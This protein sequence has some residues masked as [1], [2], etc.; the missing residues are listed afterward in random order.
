MKSGKIISG[1]LGIA[2]SAGA[3]GTAFTTNIQTS[4]ASATNAE[5]SYIDIGQG[6][7][8]LLQVNGYTVLID[9]GEKG[10]EDK[11]L[12]YLES[13]DIDTINYVIASHPHSDHIGGLTNI[14]YSII[15]GK[16]DLKIE[17]IISCDMDDSVQPTT[18]VYKYFLEDSEEI[19]ANFEILETRKNIKLGD[20]TLTLIPSPI[21]DDS[22]INNE[23]IVTLL[24]NGNNIFL[25]TGDAETEEESL[26][27]KSNVFA[28][29]TVDVYKAGHHG[30]S[31]ASSKLLLAEIKPKYTVISC[32][33]GNSY[34]HPHKETLS[35]LATYN[36]E[37]LRTDLQGTIVFKS[38]GTN[39]SFETEKSYTSENTTNPTENTTEPT[40]QKN[41]TSLGDV[42]SDNKIDS[43]DAVEV[44][45]AYAEI[46]LGKTVNINNADVNKDEKVDSK[47]VL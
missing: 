4:Y 21:K 29:V 25:F 20:S 17:N 9:G 3:F 22:N 41:D 19:G 40:D 31:D 27:V 8:E 14:M 11:I 30:S 34:G 26:L 23:S 39:L 47:D 35:K 5:I 10:S 32:A 44:L 37:V 24:K 15:K 16:T 12:S 42:N 2:L 46:I 43:K 36:S 7:S 1:I 13:K 45:K 6:D 38:D 18:T 33:A 28:N